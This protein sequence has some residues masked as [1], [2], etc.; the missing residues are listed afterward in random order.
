MT[1]SPSPVPSAA[2]PRPVRIGAF[3]PLGAVYGRGVLRGLAR[4]YREQPHV[5]VLK[6]ND[7]TDFRL[8]R[9][10]QLGLDGII[11][12]VKGR[13][14]EAMLAEL[15][16][17]TINFSGQYATHRIPTVTTDDRRLGQ[18]AFRHFAQ[19]GYRH[20]A[21]CG[22]AGHHASRLRHEA[23]AA[24]VRERFPEAEV[25]AR[26]VPEADR[27]APFP[28]H[29]RRELEAWILALPKPVALF[30]FTDR[31]ALEADEVC[32][33]AALEVPRTVALLGVGNDSTRIEFAHVPLSSI[34]LPTEDNGYRAAELLERWRLHGERPPAISLVAPRRLVARRSSDHL[35]VPDDRVAVALDYIHEH[36]RNPIRVDEV[37]RAAGASR[38]TLEVAFRQHLHQSVYQM[39][40]NLKFE[41]ALELLGQRDIPIGEI[42]SLVG[43]PEPKAFSRAFRERFGQSPSEYRRGGPQRGALPQA[44]A[45]F[46]N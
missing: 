37:A 26:F 12:R 5:Q 1:S 7:T 42:A 20:F 45:Q 4:Y 39:V 31:L 29:V 44:S 22:M 40:Q 32:R 27:D 16:I 34:E 25:A 21:F 14:E 11:A 23:F 9:L 17:P 2:A 46:A 28:E 43:F 24:A 6:F 41:H 15:D 19:R 35:A 10:R 13:R 8:Q 30:T 38:R 18:M 3:L 33:R 36:L